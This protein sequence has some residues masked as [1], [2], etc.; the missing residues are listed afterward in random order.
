[1]WKHFGIQLGDLHAAA[2]EVISL[3]DENS[4]KV[5]RCPWNETKANT[6]ET[7]KY[8]RKGVRAQTL[9][10]FSGYL[11]FLNIWL[12]AAIGGGGYLSMVPY[13]LTPVPLCGWFLMH[14]GWLCEWRR[15]CQNYT[16]LVLESMVSSVFEY[17]SVLDLRRKSVH[18][19]VG[20][21]ALET[22]RIT[23]QELTIHTCVIK[24]YLIDSISNELTLP[25]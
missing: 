20:K 2:S 5:G 14:S 6:M 15:K 3:S 22:S 12:F 25:F 8:M 16:Q 23:E 1:M 18:A 4:E 9:R 19:R 11:Q 17:Q 24:I 13:D 21:V 7:G 10:M